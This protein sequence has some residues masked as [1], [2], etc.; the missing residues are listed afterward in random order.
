MD[1]LIVI[2]LLVLCVFLLGKVK[3]LVKFFVFLV[4]LAAVAY[5]LRSLGVI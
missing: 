4:M 3:R 1:K 2:A 5:A